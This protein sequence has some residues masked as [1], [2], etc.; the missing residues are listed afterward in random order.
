MKQE[1]AKNT[2]AKKLTALRDYVKAFCKQSH[3]ENTREYFRNCLRAD[4]GCF[5]LLQMHAETA[6]RL[7]HGD[8]KSA[9]RLMTRA[10][11]ERKKIN[12]IITDELINSVYTAIG[13]KAF[14]TVFAHSGDK[15]IHELYCNLI[16]Y[17]NGESTNTPDGMDT[18]QNA[19]LYLTEAKGKRIY[20]YTPAT[21]K[22]NGHARKATAIKSR[23][24]SA[25]NTDITAEKRRAKK[26]VD[27][28]SLV[29][30]VVSIDETEKADYEAVNK[31]VRA[32]N[33]TA[34]QLQILRAL[35]NGRG[36]KEIAREL[37][38]EPKAVRNHRDAIAKKYQE[39]TKQ[40]TA[41]ETGK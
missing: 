7:Y 12:P 18:A 31:V 10:G 6:R 9:R 3:D 37:N 26:Y 33:L 16:N 19:A 24:Y 41:P 28:D 29:A 20:G 23:I 13:L 34:R 27:F 15:Y 8:I 17:I 40:T 14:K 5:P 36:V 30:G 32:L 38:I 1:T 4:Y 21:E 35:Y 2:T 11:K 22:R 25:I 39:Y